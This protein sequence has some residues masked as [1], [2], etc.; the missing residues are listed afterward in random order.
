VWYLDRRGCGANRVDRGDAPTI[1]RLLRDISEFI[2]DVVCASP[3]TPIFLTACSWGGKLATAFCRAYPAAVDGL[4]LISPGFF[5]RVGL[6][7]QTRVAVFLSRLLRPRQAFPIPLNDPRLFTDS[8]RWQEFIA[9]DPLALR[10]AT[11]RFL[12]LSAV[13][14]LYLVSAPRH[15]RIPVL[16]LLAQCDRIIEVSRTRHYVERFATPDKTIIEYEAAHHTLEFE[17]DP[18]RFIQDLTAWFRRHE[19]LVVRQ[20]KPARAE[21]P[22]ALAPSLAV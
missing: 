16:L 8:P 20:G 15:I 5:P 17:P 9:Q 11:A 6:P 21:A 14:D 18:E 22:A 10:E 19:R 2:T 4:V 3:V 1:R 7:W 12:F 13:L